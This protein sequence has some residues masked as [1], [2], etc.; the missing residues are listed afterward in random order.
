MTEENLPKVAVI[1]SIKFGLKILF[2]FILLIIF[3]GSTIEYPKEVANVV[4][5]GFTL[6]LGVWGGIVLS[7]LS[8]SLLTF[9]IVLGGVYS[10]LLPENRDRQKL[11][12]I[13]STVCGVS[14]IL[15]FGSN[16]GIWL[17]IDSFFVCSVMQKVFIAGQGLGVVFALC[18]GA[19]TDSDFWSDVRWKLRENIAT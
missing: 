4:S 6:G 3:I 8:L 11:K 12:T 19:S 1:E 15:L 2:Q 18:I 14:L 16:L 10:L 17:S 13:A 7:T 5:K 9:S